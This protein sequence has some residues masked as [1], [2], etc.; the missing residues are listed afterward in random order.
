MYRDL[1]TLT[2]ER[3]VRKRSEVSLISE[4]VEE[5][6]VVAASE[7]IVVICSKNKNGFNSFQDLGCRT[8]R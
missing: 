6:L 4:I 5:I 1:Q 7:K 3:S 2:D 8:V